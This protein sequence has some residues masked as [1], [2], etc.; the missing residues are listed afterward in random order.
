MSILDE[1]LLAVR[2][3]QWP[4]GWKSVL[5][6]THTYSG[7][8][9]HGGPVQPPESYR[10]LT[11]WAQRCGV[12]AIGMGSPFTPRSAKTYDRYDGAERDVYYS[13]E[14]DPTSV[15][16][17][18][19]IDGM[20]EAA[21]LAGG[22]KTH[23]FLDNET[24]KGRYGHMWWLGWHYDRP[25]W[26]DYDQPFD[27]WMCEESIDDRDEPM[28]Y[29]R[30]PYLQILANQRAH[31]ALGFWAHPTSWWRGDR[32]QFITNLATEMPAHAIAQGYLDG[33]V[34]MGYHPYRPQYLAIWHEL[35]DR[36]YRVTG[37]A[38]MDCGL[39]DPKLWTREV[40]L[41]NHAAVN[42][43]GLS[44]R[45]LAKTF[46]DGLVFASSGPFI[47]L[48]VDGSGMGEVVETSRR[49]VH[50]VCI[51]ALCKNTEKPLGRVEL[52]GRGG[53]VV[54]H[55]EDFAG[56][57]A[58]IEVTGLAGRGYLIARAFGCDGTSWRDVREVAISN[59]V[60]LHPRGSGFEKPATTRVRLTI[61]TGSPYAGGTV[62]FEDAA[63]QVLSEGHAKAGT[64]DQ[65]MPADGRVTL[66]GPDGQTRTD[67][68][69]NANTK[70]QSL[71]RYLYR[72]RFLRDY[73]LLQPGE[74]PP[75]AW[76]IDGYV[77]AMRDVELKY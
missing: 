40:A 6:H 29:E 39:S 54:W 12:D 50:S 60:Y 7:R 51:T 2:D 17:R 72:G 55:R 13:P 53:E 57:T 11:E 36:G 34:I 30:R 45:S 69:V 61:A 47:N 48:S 38:E 76:N 37:V 14:F 66:R 49:H 59:P 32:G 26:H 3:R 8:D 62:S 1:Q 10:R 43:G 46:G 33:M 74:C 5:C 64:I 70:L 19:E 67:Y 21:R 15:M 20:L 42:G 71:Q 63:G 27:R 16:S 75:S 77:D 25:A 23:F 52:V 73:P 22:G 18:D 68:L 44:A 9:D 56:G 58:E 31:G 65:T 41:L 35:L 4:T 28:P 24:P